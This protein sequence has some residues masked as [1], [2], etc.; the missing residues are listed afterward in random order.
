[1]T[2]QESDRTNERSLRRIGSPCSEWPDAISGVKK[3][4]VP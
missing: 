4:D 3:A 1:M 2:N